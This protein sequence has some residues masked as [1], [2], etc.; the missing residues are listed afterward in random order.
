MKKKNSALINLSQ[1]IIR[2]FL[3]ILIISGCSKSKKEFN[4]VE[5]DD[6]TKETKV[7]KLIKNVNFIFPENSHAFENKEEI[8]NRTFD[9][10]EDNIKILNKEEFT[11]TIYVRVMSSRDEMF[12]YTGTR[13]FGNTYP[14]W[15]TLYIVANEDEVNPPI[16]HEL[17]HLIAMLDWDYSK[18]NSTWMNEGIATYAANDCN[19]NNVEEIYRF[20]L[21][22]D[23]LISIEDLTTDFYAQSDMVAYHQSAY[24]V[25]YLLENYGLEKFKNL[26]TQGYEKFEEIYGL[27]YSKIKENLEDLVIEKYPKAPKIDWE[28]F[29]KGCK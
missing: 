19:G 1:K 16:K 26:W 2:I 10:I 20:L 15:S 13:A 12:I 25:Q 23:K 11:D 14:Y 17:M 22:E 29:S 28:I 18:R 3:L 9:A 24:I 21:E 5:N 27:P 8:I 7:S 6:W 4:S